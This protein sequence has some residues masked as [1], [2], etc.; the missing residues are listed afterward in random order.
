LTATT[1]NKKSAIIVMASLCFKQSSKMELSVS[2]KFHTGLQDP[3]YI[4]TLDALLACSAF[5]RPARAR[6]DLGVAIFLSQLKDELKK[7][8]DKRVFASANAPQ[9]T[10]AIPTV[11]NDFKVLAFEGTET[12]SAL[13]SIRVDLVSEYPDIDLETLLHQP[14]FLQF[15]LNGEG[16]H[17][18]IEGVSAGDAGKRLTRYRV[19]LVPALHYLQFSQDQRIFQD[20]TVPQIIDQVLKG[21]GIQADAFTFH[22]KT[23]PAREYCTQYRENDLEFVQRLCAEDGITWHHQHSSQGHV[24][25]FTDDQIFFPKLGETPYQQDSGMVAEHPVVSQ[26]SM[27]FKTRPSIVTRRDYDLKRPSA[28]LESR[29]TAEF[30]PKLEDYSYPLP[31]ESE[32]RG[33]QLAQQALERHRV[34]YQ[35]AEGKSDQPTLRSGHFFSLKT[36]HTKRTTIS[37]CYLVLLTPASNLRCSRSSSPARPNL[38]TA[39]P[40]ATAT[41]SAQFPGTFFTGLRCLHLDPC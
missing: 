22:V 41:A 19:N 6:H 14:A 15:G 20:Q 35:L 39:L 37:G 7:Q 5:W 27:G 40:R 32:K 9:F 10:L 24:L 36:P 21:H 13:Y 28:L 3:S 12:I 31:L 25:V 34:D 1:A 8:K 33:K 38:R 29:F 17:G 2:R 18:H 26:F 23:S 11:R 16:V 30:D 4:N